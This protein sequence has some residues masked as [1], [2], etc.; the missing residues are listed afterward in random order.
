[1]G[2]TQHKSIGRE[3]FIVIALLLLGTLIVGA[4]YASQSRSACCQIRP[5][6]KL[7]QNG[8]RSHGDNRP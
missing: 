8:D 7:H 6:N 2:V 5:A 1:M 3:R 4:L